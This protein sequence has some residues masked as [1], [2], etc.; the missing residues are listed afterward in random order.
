[1]SGTS[2][3]SSKSVLPIFLRAPSDVAQ[4]EEYCEFSQ[5][6]DKSVTRAHLAVE[7]Y[8]QQT[9]A[10]GV[11]QDLPREVQDIALATS[12]NRDFTL[13]PAS[14]RKASAMGPS[15]GVSIL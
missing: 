2:S 7:Q 8:R 1:M 4:I 15:T 6:V 13:V 10:S 3:H 9:L 14:C 11:V 5:R 12:E